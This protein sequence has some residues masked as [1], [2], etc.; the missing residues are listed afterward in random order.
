MQQEETSVARVVPNPTFNCTYRALSNKHDK[1]CSGR[2]TFDSGAVVSVIHERML[3]Y[4]DF[5]PT[6]TRQKEYLGA[7]GHT[8]DLLPHVVDVSVEVKNVGM[9]VFRK[10]LVLRKTSRVT[11]TLLI[12]RSDLDRLKV[13]INFATKK[14]SLGSGTQRKAIPMREKKSSKVENVKQSRIIAKMAKIERKM[15]RMF[16][17]FDINMVR[18]E[19]RDRNSCEKKNRDK[20]NRDKV[21]SN[22]PNR[23]KTNRD[24]TGRERIKSKHK[25]SRDENRQIKSR[26]D[27]EGIQQPHAIENDRL[28]LEA[29]CGEPCLYTHPEG[30]CSGCKECIDQKLQK[31][32]KDNE[33]APNITDKEGKEIGVC[34]NQYIERLRQRSRATYT[35]KEC[36]IDEGFKEDYPETA[37]KVESLINE[38]RDIFAADIGKVSETYAADA[39]ITGKMSPLRP[40]HQQFQ[41]T[42]LLAILKQFAKQIADG[43]LVDVQKE[44]II[45]KNY[46][47][48][49]PIKKKDDDGKILEA[50]SSLRVVVDSTPVNGQTDYKGLF[51]DNLNDGIHFAAATSK[52]GFN[53]K[54]DIGDAFYAIP[55]KRDKW[56][57][58]CI[59]VPFLGTYCYTRIVQGWGPSAQICQEVFARIFFELKDNMRRYMDDL[60]LATT[61]NEKD[62]IKLVEKFFKIVRRNNLRLKGKKCFFGSKAFNFLGVTINKGKITASPHYVAKLEQIQPEN[63]VTKTQMR[64]YAMSFAFIA[65]FFNR[66]S[67]MMKPLR[68]VMSGNGKDRIVW[69]DELRTA[70]RKVQRALQELAKLYP[71]DPDLQTVMV[72]D[73]SKEATGGFIYQTHENG[74]RLISFFSRT[75]K[76]KERKITLSSCHIELLGLKV[77]ILAFIPILRQSRKTIIALTDSAP[78]VQIWNK[79]KKHELPSHDTRIN[80]ALYM[81]ASSIDLNIVHAKNTNSKLQFADMLSRLKLIRESSPCEGTPKCPIC[82]AADIDD[83]DSPAIIQAIEEMTKIEK[84]ITEILY[85]SKDDGVNLIPDEWAFKPWRYREP[86]HISAVTTDKPWTLR[87]LLEDYRELRHIQSDSKDLR[88]LRKGLEKSRVSFPKKLQRLHTMLESR[89]AT[90]KSGVIFMDKTNGGVTRQIIPIPD[91]HAMKIIAA[92]HRTVGHGPVTQTVQQVQRYFE[93]AKLKEKVEKFI[94]QCVKCSLL[95]GGANYRKQLKPVPMPSDMFRSVLADE[96]TRNI[97]NKPIKLLVAMEAVSGFMMVVVYEGAMNGPKFI[98]AMGYV[99]AVLCPHNMDNLKIELRC[100]QAKWHTGAM[101]SEGLARMGIELRVHTS[102][103][104]SH[105]IIPELDVKIKNYSRYLIQLV[106]ETPASLGLGLPCHLAAAK[107]NNT[108]GSS[109]Y[110]PAELFIGRGWKNNETIQL[111]VK[112]ILEKVKSRRKIRREYE[113]RKRLRNQQKKEMKL[114]PYEEMEL[115]SD[116]VKNPRLVAIKEGDIVTLKTNF[117]KNEPKAAYKVEKVNFRKRQALLKRESGLDAGTIIAKWICFS[118]IQDVFPSEDQMYNNLVAINSLRDDEEEDEDEEGEN[119]HRRFKKFMLNAATYIVNMYAAPMERTWDSMEE[120]ELIPDIPEPSRLPVPVSRPPGGVILTSDG[121]KMEGTPSD[122]KDWSH[123]LLNMTPYSRNHPDP[124]TYVLPSPGLSPG[125]ISTSSFEDVTQESLDNCKKEHPASALERL[126]V[127]PTKPK[128]KPKPTPESRKKEVKDRLKKKVAD[129]KLEKKPEMKEEPE[130]KEEPEEPEVKEEKVEKSKVATKS[131]NTP[132]KNVSKPNRSIS[133]GSDQKLSRKSNDPK[134]T[135]K[136]GVSPRIDTGLSRS[137]KRKGPLDRLKKNDVTISTPERRM[138]KMLHAAAK[139]EPRKSKKEGQSEEKDESPVR[140]RSKSTRQAAKPGQKLDAFKGTCKR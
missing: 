97:R 44:G 91:K 9:V 98:A 111:N 63:I 132:S 53:I 11:R 105:N 47:Q 52:K 4:C 5:E 70:F 81:I 131:K 39:N 71:F 46:L 45:P 19:S 55:L 118:R 73:T 18:R 120:F 112:E 7:G 23:D 92:V 3:E 60:V 22:R 103:T 57:Y 6:G 101:V 26:E 99:K 58:F 90:L 28:S 76:D 85:P 78:T 66:S 96:I 14:V 136:Q 16:E 135:P 100:D 124:H 12:G 69:T 65:K 104:L 128:P 25:K 8:L 30:C 84:D 83:T 119:A 24:S 1:K 89:N 17:G 56:G 38:Y 107:C 117:N 51:T 43:V 33:N 42:T 80:N 31:W 102:T 32:I 59:T 41:G 13:D 82:K 126:T 137:N 61:T 106:E 68:D 125:D 49:L 86:E 64:S 116:L 74:P 114:V 36:T 138:S 127:V 130:V 62:Y 75:R 115:N 109:G 140:S 72:V 20:T 79:F 77:M 37:A 93:V 29:N 15:N 94:S 95:K 113:D 67:E 21:N 2:I 54:A 87:E 129:R 10:V 108:M 88:A 134:T 123:L 34:L 133:F 40:G 35:H 48:V 50:L 27:P 121:P 110:T 122:Q 139:K